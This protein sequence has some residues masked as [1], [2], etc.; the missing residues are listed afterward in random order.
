M[1]IK[2]KLKT[3]RIQIQVEKVWFVTKKME[4]NDFEKK[5]FKGGPFDVGM[6]EEHFFDFSTFQTFFENWLKW[7][8]NKTKDWA[9]VQNA[10]SA[11]VIVRLGLLW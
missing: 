1:Y 11:S 7:D 10:A 2:K 5:I 8:I 6:V 3:C 4:K 9:L